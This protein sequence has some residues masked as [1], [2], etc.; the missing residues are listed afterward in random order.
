[1]ATSDTSDLAASADPLAAA[2]LLEALTTFL[3]SVR[4]LLTIAACTCYTVAWGPVLSY[5][6]LYA[7]ERFGAQ[8]AH[9]P[10]LRRGRFTRGWLSVGLVVDPAPT[11]GPIGWPAAAQ[12]M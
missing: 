12:S 11:A 10:S 4:C 8:H 3:S 6:P 9:S 2:S 7:V 5:I 1:M